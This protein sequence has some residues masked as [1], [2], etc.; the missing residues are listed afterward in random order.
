MTSATRAGA[1]QPWSFPKE[2]KMIISTGFGL[3]QA[4]FKKWVRRLVARLA[5]H[6]V[7]D[8]KH[9]RLLTN[10]N[11]PIWLAV[12]WIGFDLLLTAFGNWRRSGAGVGIGGIGT[13]ALSSSSFALP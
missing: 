2:S 10:P 4:Q 5:W 13:R 7:F 6:G 12:L 9:F 1:D 3:R 11:L 8:L